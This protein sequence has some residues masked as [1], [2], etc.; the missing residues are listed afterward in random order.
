M[1]D[2]HTLHDAYGPADAVPTLL[3]RL[4]PEGTDPAWKEL[5]SRLC[6]QG[7]VYPASFAALPL[8]ESLARAWSAVRRDPILHLAGAIVCS[9]DR[10]GVD[11][12]P[13][14]PLGQTIRS[15]QLLAAESLAAGHRSEELFIYLLQAVCGLQADSVWGLRLDG[16]VDGELP[17]RCPTCESE[18]YVVV[19]DDGAFVTSEDWV[20]RPDVKREPI[21]PG[22]LPLDPSGEGMRQQAIGAG[23]PGVGAKIE[24]LFGT[25]SCPACT[26]PLQVAEA[27]AAN[28]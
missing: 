23:H 26:T 2:W 17:A 27:I 4:R 21:A 18:L 11:G 15:L 5:W 3:S 1:T 6:H 8:L 14:T 9:A 20:D 12:D 13:L 10:V 16:L 28:A 7:T 22:V 25:T 24:Y 19:G